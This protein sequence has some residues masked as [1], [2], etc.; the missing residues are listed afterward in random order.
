VRTNSEAVFSF[1]AYSC[2][3]ATRDRDI[4]NDAVVTA[5]KASVEG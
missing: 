3:K 4:N 5:M 2:L 1:N